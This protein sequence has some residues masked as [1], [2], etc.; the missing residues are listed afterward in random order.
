MY[1]HH[2][3]LVVAL[4]VCGLDLGG[5]VECAG[6]GVVAGKDEGGEGD[7]VHGGDHV[8]WQPHVTAE[9]LLLGQQ[10]DDALLVGMVAI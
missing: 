9:S 7:V 5:H 1:F 2:L 10:V 6:D 3:C 4:V 8:T